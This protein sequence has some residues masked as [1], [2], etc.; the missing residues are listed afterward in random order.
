M[1]R[2]IELARK[3]AQKAEVYQRIKCI[4]CLFSRGK[5]ERIGR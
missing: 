4:T 2:I 3:H 5:V 1:E